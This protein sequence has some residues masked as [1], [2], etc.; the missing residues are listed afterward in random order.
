MTATMF[1]V[2]WCRRDYIGVR[3]ECSLW[4]LDSVCP[5]DATRLRTAGREWNDAELYGELV[6]SALSHDKHWWKGPLHN[7][8]MAKLVL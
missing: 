6:L 2:P 3:R 7:F 8:Q 5:L 4:I 1:G